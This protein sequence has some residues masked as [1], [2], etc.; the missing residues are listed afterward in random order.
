M[1]IPSSSS[2]S[3]S[4]LVASSSIEFD[5]PLRSK[6]SLFDDFSP[7]ITFSIDSISGGF[8]IAWL[9]EEKEE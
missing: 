9:V 6:M 5:V 2:L 1:M 8:S 7:L 4:F 3:S